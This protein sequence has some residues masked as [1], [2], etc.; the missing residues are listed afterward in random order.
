M[1]GIF[2]LLFVRF[3]LTYVA[4]KIKALILFVH[5]FIQKTAQVGRR[6]R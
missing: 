3:S 2:D 6:G 4:G 1:R 5:R